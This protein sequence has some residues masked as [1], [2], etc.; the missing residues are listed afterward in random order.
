MRLGLKTR[1]S[2]LLLSCAGI[3]VALLKF[4]YCL[5]ADFSGI[6]TTSYGCYSDIPIFWNSHLFE[7]HL[8]PYKAVNL[9]EVNQVINPIEYPF[10]T[11][12]VMW[13]LSYITPLNGNSDGNYFIV[14]VIFISLLFIG[15]FFILNKLKDKSYKLIALAPSVAFS[16]FINWDMWVVYTLLV[17]LYFYEKDEFHKSSFFLAISISFKLFPVVIL[18]LVLIL[19]LKNRN[20][21]IALTYVGRVGAYFILINAPAA[22]YNFEGWS[23]FYRISS[24]RGF[25][26]GSIW[27]I[28]DLIGVE[29]IPDNLV[30]LICT[31]VL[32]IFITYFVYNFETRLKLSELTYYYIF[33]F[34]LFNKIYSPQYVIWLTFLAALAVQTLRH[35]VFFAVWQITELVYHFAIWRY[36]HWQGYGMHTSGL[37]PENYTWISVARYTGM[38]LFTL[39]LI[40]CKQRIHLRKTTF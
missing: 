11:G 32:F 3:A 21:R 34:V 9:Q 15:S 35:K 16:L 7:A 37:S 31:F 18:P 28:L 25:G 36:I 17:A 4:N 19:G 10:L 13:L 33:A 22:I 38:I 8:W 40:Q 6:S 39:S 27:E 26:S 24:E 5:A 30:F 1:T 29:Y 2:L 20:L 23:F 12:F 14:N